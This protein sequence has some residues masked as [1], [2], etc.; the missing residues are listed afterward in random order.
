MS[1]YEIWD[2]IGN[3]LAA[4]GTFLA[5]IVAL[6]F[7]K[8]ENHVKIDILAGIYMT[9]GKTGLDPNKDYLII[10]I[11]NLSIR[12]TIIT[13]VYFT[14]GFIKK[15]T[16]LMPPGPPSDNLPKQLS[17]GEQAKYIY[18]MEGKNI[19]ILKK[20]L[21]KKPKWFPLFF[22]LFFIKF[23]VV[24]SH[25]K[26]FTIRANKFLKNSLLEILKKKK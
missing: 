18:A 14:L 7:S 2:L 16:F 3:Y 6:Y 26:I 25:G 4:S 11:T 22:K 23:W 12:S 10:T 5:V 21:Y 24:N 17:D 15:S 8:K 1:T 9:W 20:Y 13:H 19:E